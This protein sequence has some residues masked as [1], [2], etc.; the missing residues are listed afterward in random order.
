MGAASA[1]VI[2]RRNRA[3]AATPPAAV[4]DAQEVT[5]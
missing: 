5:P 1:V 2:S 4:L 3:V